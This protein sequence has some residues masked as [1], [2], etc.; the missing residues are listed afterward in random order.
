MHHTSAASIRIH[1]PYRPDYFH[2]ATT[3]RQS[4]F[5]NL[6]SFVKFDEGGG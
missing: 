1:A 5:T 2:P 4:P 6:Q 3:R